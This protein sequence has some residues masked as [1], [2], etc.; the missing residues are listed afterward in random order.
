MCGLKVIRRVDREGRGGHLQIQSVRVTRVGSGNRGEEIV[1]TRLRLRHCAPNKM[2]NMVGKNQTRLCEG[3][4]EEESVVHVAMSCRRFKTQRE[5]MRNNVR[6]LG[7][8]EFT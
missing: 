5:V 2:L 3:C 4:Q 6:E 8:Q 7:M 1:L